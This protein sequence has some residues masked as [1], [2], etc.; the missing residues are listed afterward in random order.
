MDNLETTQ[1]NVEEVEEVEEVQKV[2]G[3]KIHINPNLDPTNDIDGLVS[4]I[5]MCDMV[6]TTSNVTAHL[7]GAIGKKGVVLL[8]YS[9]GKIWYWHKG[10]GPSLWYPSLHLISQ[11]KIDDWSECVDGATRWV[12]ENM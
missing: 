7:A 6:V 10:E 8:P 4:Q 11:N 3:I 5:N 12:K 2:L 1:D 9:R